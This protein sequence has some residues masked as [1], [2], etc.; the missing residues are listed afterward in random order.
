LAKET[1]KLIQVEE[2]NLRQQIK[3]LS[4]LFFTVGTE[5]FCLKAGS[6]DIA[7]TMW[8]GKSCTFIAKTFLASGKKLASNTCHL[9]LATP[10]EM[11]SLE[12]WKR[13][14][15]I[16][17]MINYSCTLFHMRIRSMEFLFHLAMKLP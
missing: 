17:E 11:K 1:D 14:I 8:D 9:C 3:N 15:K 10:A 13:P 6:V 16:P 4:D 12:V 5:K 7:S 2:N